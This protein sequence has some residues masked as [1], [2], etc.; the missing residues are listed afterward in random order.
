MRLRP[1]FKMELLNKKERIENISKEYK[2]FEES[3]R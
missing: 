1:K 2:K 3:E